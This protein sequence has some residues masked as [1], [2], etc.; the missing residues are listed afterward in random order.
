MHALIDIV[1]GFLN[2]TAQVSH[3]TAF[4]FCGHTINRALGPTQPTIQ[5][6]LGNLALGI[7]WLGYAVRHL[8]LVPRTE[9]LPPVTYTSFLV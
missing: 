1:G 9:V 4:K 3:H 2:S 5:C 7:K 8:C 6:I